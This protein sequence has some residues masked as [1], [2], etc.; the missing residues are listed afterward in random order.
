MANGTFTSIP[1]ATRFYYFAQPNAPTDP[2]QSFPKGLRMLVGSPTNKVSG[3]NYAQFD[4]QTLTSG[5]LTRATGPDFNFATDCNAGMRTELFFPSCWDGLNL[6]KA[7]GSHMSYTASGNV[8]FGPCPLSHPVKVPAMLLEFTWQTW[9]VKAGVPLKGNLV[10]A[11]GDTTGAGI[12]ADFINGWDTTVLNN[13]LTSAS[14]GIG[15]GNSLAYT[16]CPVFMASNNINGA[17]ACRPA[18]GLLNQPGGNSDNVALSALPGCNMPYGTGAK[19]SCGN[20]AALDVSA[21]TGTNGAVVVPDTDRQDFRLPTTAA[22]TNISC[23]SALPISGG[24]SYA[25]TNLSP[26]SC[27][28]SCAKQ[29]YKYASTVLRGASWNCI[30]G[31]AFD[32]SVGNTPGMCSTACPGDSTQGCGGSYTYKTFYSATAALTNA[33]T[34]PDGSTD[35]GCYN[36]PSDKTTGLLGAATYSFSSSAM[37]TEVCIAA[38][39]TKGSQWAL[40]TA[41]SYCYCG[42][43]LTFANSPIVPASY[44]TSPCSGNKT[45]MCGDPYRSSVYNISSRGL[46]T[47]TD[48]HGPG[49]KGCYQEGSGKLALAANR[50]SETNLTPQ[51]CVNQCSELGYA[52]AGLEKGTVCMCDNVFNGGQLL[53]DSQC[54]APCGGNMTQT[55]GNAAS[56]ALDLYVTKGVATVTPLTIAASKPAGYAGCFT[57][58]GS[59]V[60]LANYTYTS[61]SMTVETCQ[62]ACAGFGFAYAGVKTGNQCKCGAVRP[63]TM[64]LPS[65]PNCATTCSGSTTETCGGV[66]AIELYYQNATIAAPSTNTA[67]VGCFNDGTPGLTGTNF[68]STTMS[69]DKCRAGCGELG[70][71]LSA[72]RGGTTC[73]CGNTYANTAKQLPESSCTTVCAGNSS[74]I[75]GAPYT[76]SLWKSSGSAATVAAAQ[77]K[78]WL[79]CYT[80]STSPRTLPTW[81][82]QASPMSSVVC[83]AACSS[84]GYAYAGT[85]NGNTCY[86]ANAIAATGARTAK[87]QCS[88]ACAGT[89]NSE[90]CG[91]FGMLDVYNASSASISNGIAGYRGCFSDDTLSSFAY[92]SDWM[93]VSI[94]NTACYARGFAYGGIKNGTQCKCGNTAPTHSTVES[95]CLN[96]CTADKSQ[97]CGATG[98]P[99]YTIANTGIKSGAFA[100]TASSTGLTGCFTDSSSRILPVLGL[101]SSTLTSTSCIQNCK[102]L[103]YAY[104]G[105]EGGNSCYCGNAPNATS[106]NYQVGTAACSSTCGGGGAAGTCGGSYRLS[107]YDVAKSGVAAAATPL[108]FTGCFNVGSFVVSPA[109]SYAT[110]TMTTGICRRTCKTYGYPIAGLV[111]GNKCL[112]GKT[113][114]YGTQVGPSQCQ[115]PCLGD[116]SSTC[117]GTTNSAVSVYDSTAAN[118][119]TTTG[120][121]TGYVGCFPEASGSRALPSGMIS[122]TNMTSAIC[123]AS[124]KAQG[125]RYSGTEN[126]VQCF[127]GL[128]LPTTGLLVDSQCSSACGGMSSSPFCFTRS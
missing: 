13:A 16:E 92:S 36:N 85:E 75:C 21:F 117:G 71:S 48:T 120:F 127:C 128:S 46:T 70:F 67:Y 55:C 89:T 125:Y 124:C 77:P 78:G 20:V 115:A 45:E 41:G 102:S 68:V 17:S 52:Y 2:V 63:P 40:T 79:G 98:I 39:V 111:N 14:C 11:N 114:T 81:V 126:G 112:C 38:C 96:P 101:S 34:L 35:I 43:N 49:Y 58:S 80:D 116:T 107:L 47:T 10:W 29:G 104:A 74:E 64:Q 103:N 62:K 28:S 87:S 5:T 91:G 25:D 18:A 123:M 33:T 109:Y 22:W 59:A 108:G 73:Y 7:D 1:A 84:H 3:M 113:V 8:R 83:T 50:W 69:I 42:T 37:T 54:P 97:N 100:L 72:V 60:S 12:H 93:S 88:T 31:N 24:P 6:W 122:Q 119:T 110:N 86:C 76:A 32:M 106:G 99:I 23:T 56:T 105:I 90:T 51:L 121:P 66:N 61:T 15:S 82:Y 26:A 95:A 44:C 4:C 9:A 118:L 53:P 30:C 19:P 57:D 65:G 27:Q 94:C